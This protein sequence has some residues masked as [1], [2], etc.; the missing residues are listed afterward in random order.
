ML[1]H[2]LTSQ[3]LYLQLKSKKSIK[4]P[5]RLCPAMA[6]VTL[7]FSFAFLQECFIATLLQLARDDDEADLGTRPFDS[8]ND[9]LDDYPI[10]VAFKEQADILRR[11]LGDEEN[12]QSQL[13][14]WC[15]GCNKSQGMS[16]EPAKRARQPPPRF[17]SER[18]SRSSSAIVSTRRSLEALHVD[19]RLLPEL[20]YFSDKH[21]YVNPVS[22]LIA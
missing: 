16:G 22:T 12:K 17:R 21:D 20:P 6:H 2:S 15:R 8:D 19:D 13:L 4:F 7:G 1:M 14:D 9:D 18:P 3:P 10:W 11:E 5:D